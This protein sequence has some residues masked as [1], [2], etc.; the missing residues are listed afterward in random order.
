M[1][2]GTLG[3]VSEWGNTGATGTR[4]GPQSEARE[5][6]DLGKDGVQP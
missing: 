3:L 1:Q 5:T 6:G 2:S 4:E